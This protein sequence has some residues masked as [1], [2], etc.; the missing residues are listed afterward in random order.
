MTGEHRVAGQ[1]QWSKNFLDH[2]VHYNACLGFASREA[3]YEVLPG[4]GPFCMR[5]HGQVHHHIGGLRPT[6]GR[7]PKY[8]SLYIL[9][10]QQATEQRMNMV[11]NERVIESL[12]SELDGLIREH[13]PYYYGFRQMDDL[14]REAEEEARLNGEV[15]V[16]P[17]MFLCHRADEDRRR[18][19]E[20]VTAADMAV[21]FTGPDGVPPAPTYLRIYPTNANG[22]YR[23]MSALDPNRD[24]MVYP[25]LFPHGCLGKVKKQNDQKKDFSICKP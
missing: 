2:I 14:L 10:A 20:P 21:V 12:M 1:E 24:P 23:E 8:A 4:R 18:Y 13:N 22:G 6:E 9:D 5:L 16:E 11:Y 17:R 15:F 7:A 19:N 3:N 25:I